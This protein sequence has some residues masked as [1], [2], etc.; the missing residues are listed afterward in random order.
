[1]VK[2]GAIFLEKWLAER[3]AKI[4]WC[5]TPQLWSRLPPPPPMKRPGKYICFAHNR[6]YLLTIV[7]N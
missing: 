3:L 2:R 4:L 1:M 6:L 7:Q 5:D